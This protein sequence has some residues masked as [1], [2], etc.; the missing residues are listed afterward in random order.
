MSSVAESIS[1]RQDAARNILQLKDRVSMAQMFTIPSNFSWH[2]FCPDFVFHALRRRRAHCDA[3]VLG[4]PDFRMGWIV[5]RRKSIQVP[6]S[7]DKACQ[8]W[9]ACEQTLPGHVNLSSVCGDVQFSEEAWLSSTGN[10]L[11]EASVFVREDA[12]KRRRP[13]RILVPQLSGCAWLDWA[14]GVIPRVLLPTVQWH[15]SN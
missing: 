4:I 15:M 1:F 10:Q 9:P 13:A 2:G 14:V 12:L 5:N 7:S 6:R 3:F 11:L 8:S